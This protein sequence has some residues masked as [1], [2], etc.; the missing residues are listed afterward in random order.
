MPE[1]VT[2]GLIGCGWIAGLVHIPTLARSDSANVTAI[3][4]PDAARRASAAGRIPGVRVFDDGRELLENCDCRA[5]LIALPTALAPAMAVAAFRA[6]R[7]AYVEKPGAPS[8]AE[9]RPVVDA[10]SDSGC[11]GMV[12]YNFRLNPIFRDAVNRIRAGAVGEVLSVQGRFTWAADRVDGWRAST[13]RGGGSLLDLASH[14]VDLMCELLDTPVTYVRCTTRSYRVEQDAAGI[15]L[16]F[17]EASAQ[18]FVSSAA[19]ANQNNFVVVGTDGI[20]EVDLLD[21]LPRPILRRPARL[22]RVRRA[23]IALD[24]LHPVRLLRSPGR[25][26]S[27]AAT[28]DTF[29]NSV[30][31]GAQKTPTPRDALDVLTILDA[32]AESAR[33]DGARIG[34]PS[35]GST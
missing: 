16:G 29:V 10:W 21:A 23:L 1:P 19:G 17:G 26:P 33:R 8:A 5:V 27:F 34:L 25:E 35:A 31:N 14:H 2:V 11:I 9:W 15:V 3:A 28:L 24:G 13:G 7:H 6:G 4:E 22:E 20:L 30:V 18:L 12:G 32:A